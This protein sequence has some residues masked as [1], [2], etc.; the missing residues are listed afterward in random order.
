[1]THDD[2]L[3]GLNLQ[4][5]EL[6]DLLTKF[7]RFHSSLNPRQQ[8]VIDSSLPTAVA[9]AK[10]FSPNVTPENLQQLLSDSSPSGTAMMAYAQETPAK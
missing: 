8:K 7:E 10:T 5:D 1:M 6:V 4:N 9:A 3:K 2:M